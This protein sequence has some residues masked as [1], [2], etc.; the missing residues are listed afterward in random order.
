[1]NK[2]SRKLNE[3]DWD[4]FGDEKNKKLKI[5]QAYLDC[6]IDDLEEENVVNNEIQYFKINKISKLI[7]QISEFCFIFLTEQNM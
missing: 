2:V 5:E 3:L 6:F 1:M 4:D 7:V